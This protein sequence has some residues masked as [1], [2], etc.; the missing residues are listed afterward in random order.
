[1]TTKKNSPT[2]TRQQAHLIKEA[3]TNIGQSVVYGG[4]SLQTFT[5]NLDNLEKTESLVSSLEDQI[6]AARNTLVD[7]R[8]ELWDMV[9]RSRNGA[10][11]NHG[12]DSSEY[13]R[14]GGTRISQRDTRTKKA[15][16]K[17]TP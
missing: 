5:T 8:Y 10:K 1:M 12:D 7:Q 16:S 6:T 11:A 17:P 4:L 15:T 3:W 14:F 9:K 13:E 2:N